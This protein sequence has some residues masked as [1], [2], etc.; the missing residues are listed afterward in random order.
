[1]R[2]YGYFTL[3]YNEVRDPSE[4]RALYR[5]KGMMEKRFDNRKN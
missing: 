3:M 1:M 5:S 2:N 4:D